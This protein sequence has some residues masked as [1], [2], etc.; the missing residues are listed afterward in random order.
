MRW[1][2][3]VLASAHDLFAQVTYTVVADLASIGGAAPLG[4]V[5]RGADGALYGPTSEGGAGNCGIVYRLDATGQLSRIHSFSAP[6]GCRP[7]GELA[8]GPDGSLYGVTNRGGD[9]D[10]ARASGTIFK[11][12]PNGTFTVLHRFLPPTAEDPEPWLVPFWPEAGL[13]LAPDGFFYGTVA[14]DHV[15]RISPDGAFALVHQFNPDDS[16]NLHAALILAADG[17][18]YSTSP[19]FEV[20]SAITSGVGTVFRVSP[21]GDADVLRRF[22]RHVAPDGTRHAVDGASPTGELAAGPDGKSMVPTANMDRATRPIEGLSSDS[23]PMAPLD[24]CMC[25]PPAPIS[26]TPMA[27][28]P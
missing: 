23:I 7:M 10:P 6:D 4:G 13:T 1:S 12:A 2:F 9:P 3:A 20:L 28:T 25:F 18:L 17:S 24:S 21:A 22:Y 8:L 14:S 5:I 16:E 11:I 15:Y 19:S 26:R 27:P